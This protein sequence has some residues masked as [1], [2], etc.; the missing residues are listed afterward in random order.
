MSKNEDNACLSLA[1]KN[2][3]KDSN[4]SN[5]S[6][7]SNFSNKYN[8]NNN[9]NNKDNSI[10]SNNY[11]HPT[12]NGNNSD[13]PGSGYESHEDIEQ[14][15]H[16]K[17][18]NNKDLK[19]KSKSKGTNKSN[20]Q[21]KSKSHTKAR[22]H[23]NASIY[24]NG[25]RKYNSDGEPVLQLDM[26]TSIGTSI[27]RDNTHTHDNDPGDLTSHLSEDHNNDFKYVSKPDQHT[28]KV[29]QYLNSTSILI[30]MISFIIISYLHVK[31]DEYYL[32]MEYLRRGRI[33]AESNMMV[34]YIAFF[35]VF[36]K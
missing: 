23:S 4:L 5:L 27:D 15:I 25:C 12:G 14:L 10:H 3:N 22:S 16:V 29:F 21:K 33:Q 24:S 2:Y 31:N 28:L 9:N 13:S 6:N 11:N 8:K 18:K 26:G 35:F 20:E 19:S 32:L 34:L 36:R 17:R 1:T 7:L 30:L